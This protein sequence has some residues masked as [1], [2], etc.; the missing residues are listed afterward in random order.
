MESFLS[1]SQVFFQNMSSPIDESATLDA[2]LTVHEI[3]KFFPHVE[4]PLFRKVSQCLAISPA[5]D[6]HRMVWARLTSQNFWN[7]TFVPHLLQ[8]EFALDSLNL[9]VGKC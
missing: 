3:S 6:P 8:L 1:G 7:T 5:E 2:K 4:T 9:S